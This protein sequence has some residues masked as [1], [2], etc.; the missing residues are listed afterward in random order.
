M[1]LLVTGATGFVGQHFVAEL[2]RRRHRVTVLVRSED[3]AQEMNWRGD[4]RIICGDL[5]LEDSF[6]WGLIRSP[7]TLV[8]LA[9][10]GLSDFRD[11]AH[12]EVHAGSAYRFIRRVVDHGCKRVLVAGTC[13]EYGMREGSMNESMPASPEL[14]YALGK[15]FLRRSL[16]LLRKTTPFD[17][18][19]A[20]LF[21]MY[22]N[23]QNPRSVLSQLDAA[24]NRGESVFNMSGGEQL[25]DYLPVEDV[26]RYLAVLTETPA[27][28]GIVNI[29]SGNPVSV[30]RL[31]E[32]HIEERQATIRLNLG[33][34]P[35]P[36]YEPFAFWGDNRILK[37]LEKSL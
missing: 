12:F 4:V 11:L 30:R 8:H 13:L 33:H 26:A 2:I 37:S 1:N 29:C 28:V 16:E 20:R 34:Y 32:Q 5:S 14:P 23:G 18:L 25:R 27:H 7:H 9:W 15:D 36:D 17:F 10:P 24:I 19:W 35:Y 6:D 21:Y 31:V 22:G 3:R